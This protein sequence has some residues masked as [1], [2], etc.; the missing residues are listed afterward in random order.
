MAQKGKNA[1]ACF[2]LA[3]IGIALVF[4]CCW[5]VWHVGS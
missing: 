3:T 5:A 4:V 2:V 1:I